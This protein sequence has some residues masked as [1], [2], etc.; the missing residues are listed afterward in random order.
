MSDFI[1]LASQ[2]PRRSQLLDQ[3]GVAHKLLLAGPDARIDCVLD[4]DGSI[5]VRVAHEV[6][7]KLAPK[8]RI[9]LMPTS[10]RVWAAPTP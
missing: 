4:D 8:N 2:S 10:V 6:A 7:R 9:S 3:I 1:Y 5:E